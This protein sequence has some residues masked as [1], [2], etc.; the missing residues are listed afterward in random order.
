MQVGESILK[1]SLIEQPFYGLVKGVQF[2][3][4]LD[5]PHPF[6][7]VPAHHCTL[8]AVLAQSHGCV[9]LVLLDVVGVRRAGS[10]TD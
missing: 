1:G 8:M 10:V 6:L 2:V 3:H 4:L 9:L 7:P 5:G